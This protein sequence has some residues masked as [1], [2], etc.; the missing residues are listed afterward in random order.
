[1]GPTLVTTPTKLTFNDP[2]KR[3]LDE[4]GSFLDPQTMD[5]KLY[6]NETKPKVLVFV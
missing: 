4:I 5:Y 2:D 3:T 6:I 1:M